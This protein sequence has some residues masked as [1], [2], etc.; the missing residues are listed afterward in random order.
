MKT[1]NQTEHS[2]DALKSYFE[3][4]AKTPLLTYDDEQ[5]LS[6]KIQAG[7]ELAK[8]KLIE[9]NL[10]L[11]VKIAK[12]FIGPDMS[13]LDLV[14]EGN[15]GLIKAAEKFDFRKEVRF[16]TYAS[17]WIKQA[18]VRA[19]SNKRRAIRLPHRKE[20]AIRRIQRVTNELSQELMREPTLK[21]L[22]DYTDMSE[23]QVSAMLDL[24]GNIISLDVAINEKN[25]TL[26]DVF[27][28]DTYSPEEELFHKSL[29]ERTQAVLNKLRTREKEILMYRFSFYG[30]EKFTLKCIG[31]KMGISPET[32]RQ[33]EIRALKKLKVQAEDLREY[34]IH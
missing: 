2:E 11:V 6:K 18:I 25:G 8:H 21:E 30:G 23:D 20:E 26:M 22:A 19:I 24:A 17:W 9:A 16:S 28:D 1:T 10:R 14:Q 15:L 13:F 33:I 12:A 29:Q 3:Q 32:V 31:E 5:E 4:I 27:E 7:D 34:M